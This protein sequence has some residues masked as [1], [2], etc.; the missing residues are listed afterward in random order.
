VL[1]PQPYRRKTPTGGRR[2]AR[3]IS[4]KVSDPIFDVL[5]KKRNRNRNKKE[6]FCGQKGSG[7]KVW[8]RSKR[9]GV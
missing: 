3:I 1:T 2:I 6:R 4:K 5:E 9:S 7:V 8:S